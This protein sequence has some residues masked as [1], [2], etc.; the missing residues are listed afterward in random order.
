MVSVTIAEP[1][2][3]IIR[4]DTAKLRMITFIALRRCGFFS[5]TDITSELLKT[6]KSVLMNMRKEMM[7]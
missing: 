1:Q 5:M 4:S 3:A 7:L 2:Q 6:D